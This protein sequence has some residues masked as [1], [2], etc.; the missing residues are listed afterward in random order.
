MS[1][2]ATPAPDTDAPAQEPAAEATAPPAADQKVDET[3]WKVEARKWEARAKEN[4]T[5]AQEFDKQRKAAMTDA[6]RAVA[7]AEER[8]RTAAVSEFG[9]RLAKSEIRAAASDA[10]V[11]L[12]GV[13]DYLDLGRF[14]TEAGE[15]DTKAINGFV[16]ALPKKD[17]TPSFDGGP[18]TPAPVAG[19]MN[20]ALRKA[21]GRA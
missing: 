20:A 9:Q 6:E 14:V 11:S 10:G 17:T 5:K 2:D 3:D 1:T 16:A 7:E 12:D 13:F 19:D 4:A 21:T 18:R 8:G 15:P